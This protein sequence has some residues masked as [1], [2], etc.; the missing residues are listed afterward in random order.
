MHISQSLWTLPHR[1]ALC[2]VDRSPPRAA[3]YVPTHMCGAIMICASQ[4]HVPTRLRLARPCLRRTGCLCCAPRRHL[5]SFALSASW[6]APRPPRAPAPRRQRP[7]RRCQAYHNHP[8]LPVMNLP[9]PSLTL[10]GASCGA[11]PTPRRCCVLLPLSLGRYGFGANVPHPTPSP[12]FSAAD[13]A[14]PTLRP[15]DIRSHGLPRDIRPTLH[16]RAL[17]ALGQPGESCG[18]AR[19]AGGAGGPGGRGR[20]GVSWRG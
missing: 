12:A 5:S 6:F 17:R 14:M 15:T 8:H 16:D 9:T 10:G 19:G 18:R 2:N 11:A 7:Q 20:C 4:P 1:Y 13:E 3:S